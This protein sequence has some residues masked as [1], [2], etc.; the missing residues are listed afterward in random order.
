MARVRVDILDNGGFTA[1]GDGAEQVIVVN[2]FSTEL[3]AAIRRATSIAANFGHPIVRLD[4]FV[5]ALFSIEEI[6]GKLEDWGYR[7]ADR[8]QREDRF[9]KLASP[10]PAIGE[11]QSATLGPSKRLQAWLI[12]AETL[13]G[14]R[15]A[16]HRTT[17]L[18]DLFNAVSDT[19][20]L[21]NNAEV[22]TVHQ[23]LRR[24]HQPVDVP[25][26]EKALSKLDGL[27]DG[28]RVVDD[29]VERVG[30]QVSGVNERVRD[31]SEQVGGVSH[32]VAYAS[33]QVAQVDSRIVNTDRKIDAIAIDMSTFHRET[34]SSLGSPKSQGIEEKPSLRPSERFDLHS[35]ID[36]LAALLPTEMSVAKSTAGMLMISSILSGL[37]IGVLVR[38]QFGVF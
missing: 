23:V 17:T 12:E 32:Q 6:R 1:S 10:G 28:V 16:E 27:R 26:T 13:A 33:S 30:A 22:R 14:R 7:D 20:E 25:F 36:R 21:S 3:A 38:W 4:H 8:E 15:A 29:N 18:E 5:S 37:A 35:K 24:Y 2:K 9:K 11:P 31:L 19:A 34:Q